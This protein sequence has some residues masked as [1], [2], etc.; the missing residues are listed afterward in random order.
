MERMT[1]EAPIRRLTTIVAADVAGYSRLTAADEESTLATLRTHRVEFIDL[2]IAEYRGRIANTAGDS[3]LMEFPS[4]VEALRCAV[5]LQRGMSE[6][7]A[8]IAE[9]RRIEF[10]I[11]I[12]LGDVVEQ[13]GDLLGDG[14]NV[15]A[16]LE[17]LAPPRGICLSRAAR[18][19]VRDRMDISLEDL[20]EIQVK[21]LARPIRVFRVM[22]E[23]EAPDLSLRPRLTKLLAMATA[24]VLLALVGGG[25]WWWQPWVEKVEAARP[26]RIAFPLPAAPSIA[27]LP[28]VNLSDDPEQDYFA[29]GFTED[30]I[31]N[32]AQ[33]KELFVIARNST[34]SYKGRA[35]K[36]QQVSEELG[37]RYVLEGSVRRIGEK[38]RV[39]AQLIDATDGS[40]VWAK[41]YDEPIDRLFEVQDELTREIAGALLTNVRLADL[42]KASEKR[43]KEL[44]VYDYLLRAR[45]YWNKPG[46]EAKLR[47]RK[48]AEQAI[49]ID[50]DYA[51]A[52]AILGE[53]YNSAY[54]IQWEGPEALEHAYDAARK[55]V[56]LDPL[57]SISQELLGRVYLRRGEH[58]EAIAAI[59]R[60][61]ALNPNDSGQYASLADALTFANHSEE[62]IEVMM[63]AMRLDPFYPPRQNMYLGR[64]Y[65][66]SRQ[67]DKATAELKTCA[68]RAPVYRPCYMYLAPAL[69]ELGQVAD[70]ARAVSNLLK[71]APEFSIAT[72]VEN[73]LPFVPAA[74]A[75]YISG[76]R[77]A[78]VPE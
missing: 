72:S 4:V 50:P 22:G 53:T 75:F 61:I 71:L 21:N 41:R 70:A 45:A 43:P 38:M 17:S 57:S 69:A 13:G 32:V 42:A 36:V 64:A 55:A 51:P 78:G 14:V 1:G 25:V 6:R 24:V 2:K 9:E 12:N 59:R 67:F 52:Y 29:D 49:A 11:G 60:A 54:I 19:Q 39:T 5:D 65:Y 62:A 74:M 56:A 20:G 58:D 26:D 66:F 10:R 16:R 23:G 73:H 34:F 35:V 76:L 30:L 28:F 7:N 68:A 3:L 48:L 63:K 77:K 8:E 33:S 31:T 40:H 27:I 37:V 15:A 44:S 18:D 47:A 46:K